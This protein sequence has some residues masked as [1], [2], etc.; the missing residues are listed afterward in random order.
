MSTTRLP[1]RFG[2]GHLHSPINPNNGTPYGISHIE[3]CFDYE[4][5]VEKTA[6]TT[7]TRTFALDHRQVS[8]TGH[9]GPVHRRLGH[10]PLHRGGDQDGLTDSDWA[11]NGTI[12]I[13]NNT[14]LCGDDQRRDRRGISGGSG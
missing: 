1:R 2:D 6:N 10:L 14:P 4:V 9:L 12:T 3:F 13:E 5:D 8:D 11:V 7:F